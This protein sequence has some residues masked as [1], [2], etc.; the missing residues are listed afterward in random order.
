MG[1]K[2]FSSSSYDK[3]ETVI[4]NNTINCSK[5]E[6]TDPDPKNYKIVKSE[7]I[8]EH[9][10][11]LINYPNCTNYEGDKTLLYLNVTLTQLMSQKHIDPHFS[12]NREFIS[13]FARFVPT[14]LGWATAV[15][16]ANQIGNNKK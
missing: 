10:V 2:L 11:V 4:I 15:E 6:P 7:Q 1:L 14:R 5:K 16:I 12:D 13:P 9:L 3:N 8:G